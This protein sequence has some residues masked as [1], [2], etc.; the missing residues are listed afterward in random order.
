MPVPTDDLMRELVTRRQLVTLTA[1]PT[2]TTVSV[3]VQPG[4]SMATFTAPEVDTALSQAAAAVR[5][6]DA[7]GAG[8][9]L[10][11]QA[12]SVL[13]SLAASAPLASPTPAAPA[14]T[15]TP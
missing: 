10:S 15:G 1:T 5:A 6:V 11:A 2:Q 7:V 3:A 14:A 4:G 12:Q 9:T 13:D 8:P